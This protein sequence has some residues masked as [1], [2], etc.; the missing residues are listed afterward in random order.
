[1]SLDLGHIDSWIF[2]LDNTLYPSSAKLF[3]Q[4]DERMGSFIGAL[5]E[6]DRVEAR[7]IQKTFFHSH[8]TT[9]SGLMEE[10]GVEPSEFLDYVHDIDLE[11][12]A[13]DRELVE[14]IGALPGRKL[15]FTNGDEPYAQRVLD[16]LGLGRS[17]EAIHDI[18]AADY[19]PKPA[20][21]SYAAMCRRWDINPASALF[22]EDMARNLVPAKQLG[23]VTIWVNNGSEQAVRRPDMRYIDLEI[24]ALTPWLRQVVEMA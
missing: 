11:V 12:I 9:L 18:H 14:A 23:M 8:G 3:D 21:Q 1:M 2:D 20:P 22:V 24:E 5:L 10:H 15:V 13:E 17:F 16:K 4:I 19:V 7:R 6:V